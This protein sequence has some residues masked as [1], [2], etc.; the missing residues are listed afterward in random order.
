MLKARW[1]GSQRRDDSGTQH[2]TQN[3]SNASNLRRSAL[4][5]ALYFPQL[6]QHLEPYQQQRHLETL[7]GICQHFS[8]FVS[9]D[10]SNALLFETGSSLRYFGDIHNIRR[11]LA[12]KLR[13][14]LQSWLWDGEYFQSISPAPAASLLLAR[15]GHSSLLHN[16]VQ[17]RSALGHIQ[18]DDLPIDHRIKNKLKKCGMLLLRDIWRIPRAEFRLRFG[19]EFTQ[20]LDTLLDR[21]PQTRTRWQA[22]PVFFEQHTPDYEMHTLPQVLHG[23]DLLLGKLE[24]FLKRH[25]FCTDLLTLKFTSDH[26]EIMQK[27]VLQKEIV[28]KEVEQT[29]VPPKGVQ[30]VMLRTRLPEREKALFYKLVEE[31]LRD[32]RIQHGLVC[33]SLHSDTFTPYAPQGGVNNGVNRAAKTDH[34]KRAIR[35]S[36]IS[37]AL[38]DQIASRLGEKSVLALLNQEEH[39]PEYASQYIGY[40]DSAS[41]AAHINTR[42]EPSLYDESLQTMKQPCWLIHP[43]KPLHQ[44]NGCLC[45][46]SPLT[47]VAGPQRV[48]TRWWA[49]QDI[50]R[51][52]YLAFNQQGMYV[53]I[54]QERKPARDI[55]TPT[56]RWFLHGLFG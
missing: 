25:H 39:A 24:T 36:H 22:P 10:S 38:L 41:T 56:T 30:Q 16:E 2:H 35:H 28:L 48:E 51:D 46:L 11:A 31:K 26:S 55:N 43:P 8:D 23:C 37:S 9:I 14:Q 3:N 47:V 54:F 44:K 52:Y 32:V 29:Q 49:K 42:H 21:H 45:Y 7:A 17:L 12:N 33:I 15:T 34:N 27:E 19:K 40:L 18:I 53:W 20:Y 6:S 4:W 5:Y 50:R 13:H 1:S